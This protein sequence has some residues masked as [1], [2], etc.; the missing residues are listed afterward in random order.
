MADW[1]I[2][3]QK[4]QNSFQVH[5]SRTET[6]FAPLF[7]SV[8]RHPSPEPVHR[9]IGLRLYP[10]RQQP[11]D[12]RNLDGANSSGCGHH[13]LRISSK[14]ARLVRYLQWVETNPSNIRIFPTDIYFITS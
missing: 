2:L 10:V 7:R 11:Q 8:I 13:P 14:L 1:A 4:I 5:S 3:I 9:R 6:D 12:L